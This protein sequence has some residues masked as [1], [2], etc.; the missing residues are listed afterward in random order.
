MA[1]LHSS[2][3]ISQSPCS[4]KHLLGLQGSRSTYHLDSYNRKRQIQMKA[5]PSFPASKLLHSPVCHLSLVDSHGK[6]DKTK[7]SCLETAGTPLNRPQNSTQALPMQSKHRLKSKG[8]CF[9]PAVAYHHET[10]SCCPTPELAAILSREYAFVPDPNLQNTAFHPATGYNKPIQQPVLGQSL[11]STLSK[12]ELAEQSL[13]Y[14][15]RPCEG[16]LSIPCCF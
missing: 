7:Y 15:P 5:L 13:S 1:F 11:P 16:T 2:I 12:A 10:A 8:S 3:R 4:Q 6:N 9:P 14:P